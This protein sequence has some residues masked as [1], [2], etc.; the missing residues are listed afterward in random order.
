MT[1]T[2]LLASAAALLT[3]CACFENRALE[4]QTI[5]LDHLTGVQAEE[6]A[7]PY[8]SKEGRVFRSKEVFNAITVRDHSRNVNRI[9]NMLSERDASPSNVALHFQLIRATDAGEVGAGLERIADALGEL[10]RFKGYELMSEAVVSASERGMV[11][12]SLDAGGVP[13]QLGVRIN[14]VRG[15]G[16]DGSVELTVELRRP[17]GPLLVTNVVVPIGQTVVLGSAYPGGNG[18]ALILTV[19]GE[20]GSQKLR[21]ASRN[22]RSGRDAEV[23]LLRAEEA[24]KAAEAEA[25]VEAQHLEAHIGPAVAPHADAHPRAK[26]A[27]PASRATIVSPPPRTPTATTPPPPA[28]R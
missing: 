16:N 7:V 5:S 24:L 18:N 25:A 3:L 4:V 15:Y 20:M 10:L 19:R 17:G 22:R 27:V 26:R 9:R 28:L 23:E 1:A 8:L 14:D 21:S 2:R 6:L 13:M 11:E 12:Q